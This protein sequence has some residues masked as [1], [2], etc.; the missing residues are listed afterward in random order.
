MR[1]SAKGG[2]AADRFLDHQR[3]KDEKT[4]AKDLAPQIDEVLA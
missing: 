2:E 1:D 3:A 4:K